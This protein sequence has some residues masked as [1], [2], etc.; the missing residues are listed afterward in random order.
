MNR[1]A[2]MNTTVKADGPT[3]HAATEIFKPAFEKVK[4]IEGMVFSFT[5]QPYP[6]S[7]LKRTKP[8]SDSRCLLHIIPSSLEGWNNRKVE[9]SFHLSPLVTTCLFYKRANTDA[10]NR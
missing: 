10:E 8:V 1:C 6:V 2:Y 7:L 5:M 4:S 9:E 3:L